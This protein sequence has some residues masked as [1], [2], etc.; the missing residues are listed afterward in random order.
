MKKY[1]KEK[2]L[3]FSINSSEEI[4]T[5]NK[6]ITANGL[7]APT[8][9]QPTM[10]SN[11]VLGGDSFAV[12]ESSSYGGQV[13]YLAFDGKASTGVVSNEAENTYNLIIYNPTPLLITGI[14]YDTD[15]YY[16][17][18]RYFNADRDEHIILYGS[19]TGEFTGEEEAVT[20]YTTKTKTEK[21][22]VET[23]IPGNIKAYKYHKLQWLQS[24]RYAI[25]NY[26]G[27]YWHYHYGTYGVMEI[28]LSAYE[29]DPTKRDDYA[30]SINIKEHV[31]TSIEGDFYIIPEQ[32]FYIYNLENGRQQ[33]FSNVKTKQV[34]ALEGTYVVSQNQPLFNSETGNIVWLD[35][36][37]KSKLK[38]W[39]IT[40]NGKEEKTDLVRIG[41][42]DLVV[43][44]FITTIHNVEFNAQ[45]DMREHI[46]T[47][48]TINKKYKCFRDGNKV[49]LFSFPQYLKYKF[50]EGGVE[51][52]KGADYDFFTVR[53]NFNI[54]VGNVCAFSE[55]SS[56]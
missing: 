53:P 28:R 6:T 46:I 45:K 50:T 40:K 7:I 12:K 55:N 31:V 9:E 14:S 32:D 10:S 8:F 33:I 41:Y 3:A 47:T 23:E 30:K 38:L 25:R 17:S 2:E 5:E 36:S 35:T 22:V 29:F 49:M 15:G 11:G 42:V 19:N 20:E 21:W 13:G 18:E 1:Y 44:R 52:T 43:D 24:S 51:D 34:E 48:E 37:N 26:D 16:T 56:N 39:H 54:P 27:Y 4:S